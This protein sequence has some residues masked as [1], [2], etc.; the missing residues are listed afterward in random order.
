MFHRNYVALTPAVHWLPASGSNVDREDPSRRAPDF[1]HLDL[2]VEVPAG[3][4]VAGPGRQPRGEGAPRNHRLRTDSSIGEV[5]LFASD[6]ERRAV[7]VQGIELELLVTPK[8]MSNLDYFAEVGDEIEEQLIDIF[9]KLEG[10]ELA[11]PERVLSLVEVPSSLRTY[12]GGWR[13]DAVRTPGVLLLREEGLPTIRTGYYGRHLPADRRQ[14]F[15]VS[16]LH[17]YLLNAWN[18]GNAYQ[19][20]AGNLI[21][22]TSP[23]D[24]GSD[25][26]R[27]RHP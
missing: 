17:I 14:D 9:A 8:H 11:Y 3:W 18:S 12:R 24:S 10:A 15:L 5:A 1:F 19:G 16:T 7:D 21:A 13:M 6:F 2:V 23:V 22:S 27:C 4:W 25:S 20:L 26:T